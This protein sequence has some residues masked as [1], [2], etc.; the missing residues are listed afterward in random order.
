MRRYSASVSATTEAEEANAILLFLDYGDS[1][2]A[3][4]TALSTGPVYSDAGVPMP[5]A[6]AQGVNLLSSPFRWPEGC[7]KVVADAG[8]EPHTGELRCG[9]RVV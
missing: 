1:D 6:W 4:P 2:G 3:F 5:T 7:G 9:V 8:L